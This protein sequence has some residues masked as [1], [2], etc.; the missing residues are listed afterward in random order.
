MAIAAQSVL[1]IFGGKRQAG[2]HVRKDGRQKLA[3][4]VST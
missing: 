2:S 1:F 4:T 3:T